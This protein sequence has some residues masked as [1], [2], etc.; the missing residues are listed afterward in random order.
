[1]KLLLAALMLV[2]TSYVQASAQVSNVYQ[3][4]VNWKAAGTR[5]PA[6]GT[7]STICATIEAATYG[8]ATIDVTAAAESI[9]A[10][11]PSDTVVKFGEGKFRVDSQI[12][13]SRSDITIRGSGP[14]FEGRGTLLEKLNGATDHANAIF[15]VGSA[16][17]PQED[18][19]TD[20]DLTVDAAPG[21]YTITV[22]NALGF[23][24]GQF[25]KVDADEWTSAGW[26]NAAPYKDGTPYQIWGTD[27]VRYKIRN[28]ANNNMCDVTNC[29]SIDDYSR[30]R[31]MVVEMKEV[32]SVIADGVGGNPDTI[33]F[34]TPIMIAYPVAKQSQVIRYTG[35]QVHNQG[36]GIEDLTMSGGQAGNV[37]V[38]T[39][40]KSWVKN[41]EC[42][43]FLSPCVDIYDA[44]RFQV[45]DSYLHDAFNP[46]PGGGAYLLSMRSGSSECLFENNIAVRGNKAIVARASGAGSVVGYNYMQD[47]LINYA[48]LSQEVGVNASHYPA[49]HHVLFEGNQS[50]NYDSDFTFG[51]STD[52]TIF[53]NWLEGERRTMPTQMG[54]SYRAGG[55]AEGSL[56]H[57]FYGNILG[58]PVFVLPENKWVYEDFCDGTTTTSMNV[59][60][61]NNHAAIWKLGVSSLQAQLGDPAVAATVIRDGNYDYLTDT[62]R[63][64]NGSPVTIENSLYLTGKPSFFTESQTWPWVNPTTGTTYEL[65]ATKRYD[66]V[67]EN[68]EHRVSFAPTGTLTP[69]PPTFPLGQA[70]SALWEPNND[71]ATAFTDGYRWKLDSDASWT[72]SGQ[73]PPGTA[74][75]MSI[76][77]ARLTLGEHTLQ[78]QPCRAIAEVNPWCSYPLSGRFTIDNRPTAPQNLHT[79]TQED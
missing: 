55:L 64:H 67:V 36:V 46:V 23:V 5:N 20:V 48:P 29:N 28:P 4:T 8:N 59:A 60:C 26:I 51:S 17:F 10:G 63:W 75:S 19:T 3:A 14:A 52:M 15:R 30:P 54:R 16:Q 41:I 43:N 61:D 50:Q 18:E 32:A 74:Y 40:A 78:V 72:N 12:D 57:A 7:R 66:R 47:T 35:I 9:I 38:T 37:R 56:R 33:T 77:Q 68:F 21:D 1:M 73:I 42:K 70:V 34:T 44:F 24:A 65:P 62:Q 45:L 53:R 58:R 79:S 69:V 11:C 22:T 39:T 49:P 27:R 6:A 2:L 13:I 31:R 76:P 25:V 71:E